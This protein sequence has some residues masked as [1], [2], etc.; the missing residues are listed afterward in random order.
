MK[1]FE[2]IVLCSDLDGTMLENETTIHP[3]NLKALAYFRENGGKFTI[4]T[5]RQRKSAA[6]FLEVL[7]PDFP[8]I[9]ANGAMILDTDANKILW[10]C[11]LPQEVELFL[12]DFLKRFENAAPAVVNGEDVFFLRDTHEA[13]AFRQMEQLPYLMAKVDEVD[14]PWFKIVS[15]QNN[16]LTGEIRKYY[17]QSQWNNVFKFIR[18][19]THYFEVLPFGAN[20]GE[21]LKNLSE[22]CGFQLDKTVTVGDNENDAE[23]LKVA[24]L[25]CAMGNATLEAKQNAD[26]VTLS[27]KDGG[28]AH[29]IYEL[30]KLL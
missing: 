9:T 16:E 2:G 30:D 29:L 27:N 11:T 4:A 23:M 17:G 13:R 25:G 3:E 8:I 26:F 5:G 1:K 24:G 14:K 28:V 19:G 15:C 12:E 20:K 6:H 21:A 18:S 22:M 10:S 7:K